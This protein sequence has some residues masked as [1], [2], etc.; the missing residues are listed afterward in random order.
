MTA[1]P[2]GQGPAAIWHFDV[3][4]PFAW[5]ALG[6]MEQLGRQMP[7]IM[8]PILF[9]GLLKHWGQLGPA[10]IGPKRL[11]TYRLCVFE[12]ERRGVPLRFPPAHPFNPLRA[13]RLLCALDAPPPAIRLVME[14]IWR[15]GQ[16]IADEGVW[17]ELCHDLDVTDPDALIEAKGA[18]ERLRLNTQDA[19]ASRVFGVPTLELRGELFWGVDSLPMAQAYLANPALFDAGEMRRVGELPGFGRQGP[20]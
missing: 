10:E 13:L 2:Q 19:I 5:L 14:R 16:D 11:H 3:I 4:S 7:I 15:D 20:V 12:A 8:R 17:K 6:A 1:Q 18:K 9:A